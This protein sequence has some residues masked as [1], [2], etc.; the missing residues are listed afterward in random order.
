MNLVVVLIYY[1]NDL[2]QVL[3]RNKKTI[4]DIGTARAKICSYERNK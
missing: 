4:Q 1:I 2:N 3:C